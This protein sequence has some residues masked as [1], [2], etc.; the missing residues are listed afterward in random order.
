MDI[1]TPA[2]RSDRMARIRSKDTSI[3]WRIR[4]LVHAM[5]FR[6]RLHD[7]RLPGKPDLVF[8]GRK[9][10][11]FVHGCFWHR[12]PGCR[13]T[14]LPKTRQDYWEPKFLRNVERDRDNQAALAKAGWEYF[15]AWECQMM[16]EEQ[17]RNEL[18]EF[19]SP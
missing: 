11:V 3:E 18:R 17:L 8:A 13:R 1:L 9:K 10:V 15:I 6:Y 7:K 12:H 16:D 4:Q 14:R 19:L 5:G 2:A